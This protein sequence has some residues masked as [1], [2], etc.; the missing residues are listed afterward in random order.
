MV[1]LIRIT[2]R[3]MKVKGKAPDFH[4]KGNTQFAMH[5]EHIWFSMA[6]GDIV[7][8]QTCGYQTQA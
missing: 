1:S 7:S 6:S 5:C 2:L 4:F 8:Y 3:H